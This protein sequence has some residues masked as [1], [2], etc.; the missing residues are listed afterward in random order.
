MSDHKDLVETAQ[1]SA[2]DQIDAAC[3]TML[4]GIVRRSEPI[5]QKAVE[6]FY[7]RLLGDVQ[8]YLIDNAKWNLRS[9]IER[10]VEI[11]R[12]NAELVETNHRL[13]LQA[14]RDQREIDAQAKRIAELESDQKDKRIEELEALNTTQRHWSQR[15]TDESFGD[16][17]G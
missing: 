2:Q 3:D 4:T 10:C 17:N 12:R 7:D 5:L 1:Q 16:G 8:E 13:Q 14:Q 15:W 6:Q 9:E 11:N